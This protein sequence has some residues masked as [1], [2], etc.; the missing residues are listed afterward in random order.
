AVL[1]KYVEVIAS[2]AGRKQASVLTMA[3]PFPPEAF[4][5]M[6][7]YLSEK[8]QRMWATNVSLGLG[9][10]IA[11]PQD[12]FGRIV[13]KPLREAI[14]EKNHLWD[15]YYRPTN[16][17]FLYGDRQQVPSSRDHK[18]PEKRWFVE[19]LNRIPALIAEKENEIWEL[20][21]GEKR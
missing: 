13:P 8:G 17:A 12:D 11:L 5:R 14:L 15:Q 4:D 9:T 21:K 2:V 18:N 1:E 6:G 7:L 19:E 10:G 3:N 20:A 16:W